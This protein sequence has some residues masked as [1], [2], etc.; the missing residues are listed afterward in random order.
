MK[1][2]GITA[3]SDFTMELENKIIGLIGL[4]VLVRP[5]PLM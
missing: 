5:L 1:F 3:V 4:M 2:G